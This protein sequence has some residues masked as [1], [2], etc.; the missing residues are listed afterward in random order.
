MEMPCICDC[1]KEFD[2][3]DGFRDRNSN[4]VI[5]EDC[6][7]EQEEEREKEEEISELKELIDEAKGDINSAQETI[8]KANQAIEDSKK[9]LRKLGVSI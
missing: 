2:L 7:Q 5:C 8:E 6:H 9:K 4:K 1:G 3:H